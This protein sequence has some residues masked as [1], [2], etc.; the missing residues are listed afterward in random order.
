ME[1][2]VDIAITN[3]R[4]YAARHELLLVERLGFGIHGSVH[5]VEHKL[6]GKKSASRGERRSPLKPWRRRTREPWLA[7]A[8]SG[9][10]AGP[11]AD[12][13]ALR[14]LDEEL[15]KAVNAGEGDGTQQTFVVGDLSPAPLRQECPA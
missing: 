5:V 6:K 12:P 2:M 10:A 11:E 13:E 9:A 1:P 14:G 3:A 7:P 8:A 15:A 4:A